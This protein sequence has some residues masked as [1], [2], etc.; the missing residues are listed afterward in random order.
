MGSYSH[1][2]IWD[3]AN[4]EPVTLPFLFSEEATRLAFVAGDTQ[5][6]VERWVPPAPPHRWLID[7]AVNEGSVRE[8]LLRSELLS[9][10]RSFLSGG[11]QLLS[12]ALEGILSA[13]EAPHRAASIGP[14]GPLTKED[15][16]ELWDHF[17]SGV[18]P[19]TQKDLSRSRGAAAPN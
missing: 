19:S 12:E 5:L 3:I 15:C 8:L 1:I 18:S 14:R 2:Q 11:T 6:F 17:W 4:N 10:Q 13:E 9:G 7:L 16:R